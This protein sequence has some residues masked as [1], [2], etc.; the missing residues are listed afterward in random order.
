MRTPGHWGRR[1]ASL[2]PHRPLPHFLL[3]RCAPQPLESPP[4]S[5]LAWGGLALWA[6]A[7]LDLGSPLLLLVGR[8]CPPNPGLPTAS[9]G[10][11][12]VITEQNAFTHRVTHRH[13][14]RVYT[15]THVR[16]HIST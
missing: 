2:L 13:S 12:G 4:H 11:S 10:P 3:G 1:A 14:S 8:L 6:L 9:P 5:T 7:W 16:T 15:L